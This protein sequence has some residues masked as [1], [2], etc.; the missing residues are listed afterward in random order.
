MLE[1]SG[2]ARKFEMCGGR[3]ELNSYVGADEDGRIP[4]K[5]WLLTFS[6]FYTYL[7]I[8]YSKTLFASVLCFG[9]SWISGFKAFPSNIV[10]CVRSN[11]FS[12]NLKIS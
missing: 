2:S 11:D 10:P 6:F 9:S 4:R 3:R 8:S 12:N 5:F 7:S 1:I